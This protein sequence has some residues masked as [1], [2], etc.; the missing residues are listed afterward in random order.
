[1]PFPN[2][3]LTAEEVNGF[4]ALL[5]L[6]PLFNIGGIFGKISAPILRTAIWSGALPRASAVLT[7]MTNVANNHL[8]N[9]GYFAQIPPPGLQIPR[10]DVLPLLSFP[11]YAMGGLNPPPGILGIAAD[12]L[13]PNDGIVN[14]ISM[15]G[16]VAGPI[17]DGRDFAAQLQTAIA[18]SD[19]GLVRGRYWHLHSNSTIDHADQI[20]VFT[21]PATADE[22]QVLYMLF[23][24]ILNHL[25]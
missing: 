2:E 19:L 21:N 14:T 3:T 6:V 16:P 22:V 5:P 23:A 9:L 12:Q 10:P 11:A 17:M 20:G 8:G 13:K 4:L 1:M 15:E 18:A 7:W 25:P 24:D